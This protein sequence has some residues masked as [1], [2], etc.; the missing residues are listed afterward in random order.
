MH[1]PGQADQRPVATQIEDGKPLSARKLA[2]MFGKTSG[3]WARNRMAE[4]RPATSPATQT[5]V[6][7]GA[8]CHRVRAENPVHSSDQQSC[9]P[10]VR[11]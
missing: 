3:R 5:P 4:A 7:P 10:S 2:A 9:S 8:V 1:D 11:P 6:A